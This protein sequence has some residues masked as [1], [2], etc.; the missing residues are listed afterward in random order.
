MRGDVHEINLPRSRDSVQHG[1]RYGIVVQNDRLNLSTV[2]IV[3]TSTSVRPGQHRPD[4]D[5]GDGV[6]TYALT[7]QLRNVS[8]DALGHM[9]GH[10][11]RADMDRVDEALRLVLQLGPYA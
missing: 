9:V 5:I 3:P 7:E 8:T 11:F 10:L 6:P 1:A 2:L 4:V